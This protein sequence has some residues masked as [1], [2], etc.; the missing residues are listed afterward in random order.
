MKGLFAN[1]FEVFIGATQWVIDQYIG[2]RAGYAI[3]YN[4]IA[5][6]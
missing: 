3:C 6:I 2:M 5:I 4:I 1:V